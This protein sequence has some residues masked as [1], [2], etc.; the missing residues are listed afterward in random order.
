M[1]GVEGEST[2]TTRMT[3]LRNKASG[4]DRCS[5]RGHM[6]SRRLVVLRVLRLLFGTGQGRRVKRELQRDINSNDT[7]VHVAGLDLPGELRHRGLT[8]N[9]WPSRG[10]TGLSKRLPQDETP[11]TVIV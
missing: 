5:R 6:A 8:E 9:H 11:R 3:P 1:S 4:S 7:E 10:E 2:R